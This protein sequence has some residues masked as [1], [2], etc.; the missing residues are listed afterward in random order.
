MQ[1]QSFELCPPRKIYQTCCSI[2]HCCSSGN[3]L[4]VIPVPTQTMERTIWDTYKVAQSKT[5]CSRSAATKLQYP[6]H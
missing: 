4:I 2:A 5:L 3:P 1:H 6:E